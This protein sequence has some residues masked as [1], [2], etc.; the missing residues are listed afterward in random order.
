PIPRGMGAFVIPGRGPSARAGTPGLPASL[1]RADEVPGLA[2][3]RQAVVEVLGTRAHRPLPGVAQLAAGGAGCR[4]ERGD[5][6][7]DHPLP[8]TRRADGIRVHGEE[9]LRL[10]GLLGRVGPQL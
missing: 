9:E 3:D 6:A 2:A 7:V 10:S 4:L 8:L 5:D 1:H